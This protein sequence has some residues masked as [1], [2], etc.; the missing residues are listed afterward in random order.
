L[1]HILKLITTDDR[2][3][4][5]RHSLSTSKIIDQTKIDMNVDPRRRDDNNSSR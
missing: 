3:S 2:K 1:S 5:K 4:N